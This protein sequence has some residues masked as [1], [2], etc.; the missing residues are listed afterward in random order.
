MGRYAFFNTGFEYKFGFA[1]QD[2]FDIQWFGGENLGYAADG[3]GAHQWS[4][5]VDLEGIKTELEYRLDGF[6]FDAFSKDLKGTQ[7][8]R[9]ALC[10]VLDLGHSQRDWRY[11]LGALLYHQLL[12]EPQL[13]C[14]YEP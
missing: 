14:T 4:A 12:Y 13:S 5:D 3:N 1:I 9:S 11:L 8:L 2:S 10:D 7:A 6:D